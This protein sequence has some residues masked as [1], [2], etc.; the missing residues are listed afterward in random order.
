ILYEPEQDREFLGWWEKNEYGRKLNSDGQEEKISLISDLGF[1]SEY[2]HE[3]VAQCEQLSAF[4]DR[5]YST[6]HDDTSKRYC[7]YLR[8]C[9]IQYQQQTPEMLFR[10]VQRPFA[11]QFGTGSTP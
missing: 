6:Y 4:D 9:F 11:A 1:D 5:E 10:T 8:T 2:F 3:G 7:E